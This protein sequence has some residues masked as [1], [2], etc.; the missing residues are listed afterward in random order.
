MRGV[1]LS[2]LGSSSPVNQFSRLIKARMRYV[3]AYV[4]CL[5]RGK[6][7]GDETIKEMDKELEET[8]ILVFRYPVA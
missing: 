2:I 1:R 7:G 3:P 8:T 6:V 4:D 5:E